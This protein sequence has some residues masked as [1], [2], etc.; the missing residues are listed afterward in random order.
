L[1]ALS[2]AVLDCLD[3]PNTPLP[4]CLMADSISSPV[5]A[6]AELRD[7]VQEQMSMLGELMTARL[8]ADKKAGILPSGFEPETVV[9]VILIYL[10]G[11]WRM[12]LVSYDR[13][14][15][16]QQNELFL[17]SLGLAQ[18]CMSKRRNRR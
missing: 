12:A 11:V 15:F 13:K 18:P 6:E 10:Q 8:R 5:F 14:R 7:Y 3:N 9:Q 2:T 1:Q 4:I 16:E 17:K